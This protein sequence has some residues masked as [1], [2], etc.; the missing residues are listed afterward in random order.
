MQV[1]IVGNCE[2]GK[3]ATQ[4]VQEL[5]FLTERQPASD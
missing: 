5:V 1:E 4:E 3:V 2:H